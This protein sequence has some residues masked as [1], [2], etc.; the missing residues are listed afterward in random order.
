ME[1]RKMSI[2]KKR[3]NGYE[4]WT[5]R[6][7]LEAKSNHGPAIWILLGKW[8]RKNGE[9]AC[10]EGHT[11]EKRTEFSKNV[12]D[13]SLSAP[14]S[15]EDRFDLS[16][17]SLFDFFTFLL[18]VDLPELGACERLSLLFS[19]CSSVLDESARTCFF[20]FL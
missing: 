5:F 15:P 11:R 16:L 6:A 2:F 14:L 7:R 13:A 17:A 10:T 12:P 18:S 19:L 3:C 20:D 9:M 8:N 4:K 1:G